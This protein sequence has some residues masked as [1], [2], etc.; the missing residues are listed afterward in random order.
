TATIFFTT[1]NNPSLYSVIHISCQIESL[2]RNTVLIELIIITGQTNVHF[3]DPTNSVTYRHQI[4]LP[5]T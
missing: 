4:D 2:T 3:S 5:I 1:F